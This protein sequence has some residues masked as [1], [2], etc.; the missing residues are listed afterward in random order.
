MSASDPKSPDPADAAAVRAE[1]AAR[2]VPAGK[3][4]PPPKG[5]ASPP[6]NA[7]AILKALR[8][9]WLAAAL[10]GAVAAGAVFAGVWYFLPPPKYCATA[11]FLIPSKPEGTLYDHP[12]AKTEF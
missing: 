2:P 10:L 7:L 9:R 8:R 5:H 11:K 4:P 1:S 6:L 12:E 3:R